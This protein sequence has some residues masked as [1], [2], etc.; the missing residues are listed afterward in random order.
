MLVS[1]A[2]RSKD[3][4]ICPTSLPPKRDIRPSTCSGVT[5]TAFTSFHPPTWPLRLILQLTTFAVRPLPCSIS[6]LQP[7]IDTVASVAGIVFP[8]LAL[9]ATT[10]RLGERV[11]TRKWGWDDTWAAI[12]LAAIIMFTFALF[13]FFGDVPLRLQGP[14]G[15]AIFYM[16]STYFSYGPYG[17]RSCLQSNIPPAF[18]FWRNSRITIACSRILC[19]HLVCKAEHN[20]ICHSH[21]AS[22]SATD[23]ILLCFIR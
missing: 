16:V 19:R 2:T 18:L 22:W 20:R 10:T 3:L 12:C 21:H 13:V 8:I 1:I 4:L 5:K 9:V 17:P 23:T 14:L 15:V 11:R 6:F 7:L